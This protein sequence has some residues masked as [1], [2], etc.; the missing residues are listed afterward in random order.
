MNSE[1]KEM[2]LYEEI[3]QRIREERKKRG[4]PAWKLGQV[5]LVDERQ[6]RRYE[7]GQSA[8]SIEYLLMI[9][10]FFGDVSIEYLITGNDSCS[11][12][13]KLIE[14]LTNQEKKRA[15]EILIVLG[16]CVKY[17]GL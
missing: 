7:C 9:S 3:G 12:V 8:I 10:Q 2:T 4:I 16:D 11:A 14:G 15:M 5:I 6:V 13:N 1:N 17:A